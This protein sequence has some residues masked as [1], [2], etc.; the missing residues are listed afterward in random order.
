MDGRYHAETILDSS[1]AGREDTGMRRRG[2]WAW[3][4]A[5]LLAGASTTR[6]DTVGEEASAARPATAPAAISGSKAAEYVGREVTVEGR[7]TGIHE[8]PLA[9]VLGFAQ[10][11]AGFTATILAGDRD[12]FPPDL[13]A[14]VRDK[15]VRVTGTVTAYRGKPEMALRDPSQLVLA[16]P[17]PG[18]LT[19][20]LAVPVPVATADATM[21]EVRRVLLR[22]EQ[23]LDALEDRF[24]G[25][26]HDVADLAEA[27]AA[28][29]G[30]SL[31][32]GA[33]AADVRALLGEPGVIG[34]S[35]NGNP[36]WGY[37]R[38]RSVTF[39]ADGRVMAWTGF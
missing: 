33:S 14:R 15:V 8:S 4:I 35:A 28:Q 3:T 17:V 24:D 11:F 36:Q 22:L 6:A 31:A 7:V 30:R 19:A 21:D 29:R 10:N 5:M 12:K 26:E 27:A 23:R 25:I 13:E 1:E 9:T 18:A 38:G 16:T 32:V 37:G 34:R 39:D 20:P 2:W